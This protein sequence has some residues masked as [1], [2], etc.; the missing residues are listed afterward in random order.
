MTTERDTS[1]L[2]DESYYL[3]RE[4]AEL[5]FQRRVLAE[6]TDD[7]NPVLERVKFLAILTQNLDEFFM[8]RIGGLKQQIEAGIDDPTVDGMTPTEQWRAAI[9]TAD[10]LFEAQAACWQRVRDGVL[11]DAGIDVV[12]Y[13]D[14]APSE[15]ERLDDYFESDVLPTLTP[16][17]FDPAHPFPHISNQSLSIAVLTRD[18]ADEAGETTFSRVKVP[19][20]RPRLVAVGD[21]TFVP[22]EEVI[23]HNLDALFPNV[24]VVDHSLF[25]VTRNA[26]VRRNESVAEDLVNRIEAVLKERRFAT[27]VRLEVES[28]T[29]DA[30]V[31]LL[32]THLDLAAEEVFELDGLL[33]YRGL[34]RLTDLD[35]PALKLDAWTPRD[36]PRLPATSGPGVFETIREGDVLVH[37]PYHSFSRT[38]QTFFDAA[39][40]DPDVLAIKAAIYRTAR[41]SKI[42]ESLIE[43][44]RNGKQVAVMVELKARFDEE[45]NLRWVERLEEEGIHVAYGTLGHKAHTKTALVV[46]EE[47]EGVRLYSHVAT[48]NYHSETAEKY[49]DIGLLTANR[50]IGNDL[51]ALF[52]YFTGHSIPQ[53][54]RELL[55]APVGMRERFLDL[56][57]REAEHA[58]DGEDAR[59]V[60]K[61]NRLEHPTVVRAL[62]EAS[63]AGVDIDLVVRDICRLR[64]GLDGVSETVSVRSIVGRFLEH[65]RIF[66][67]E[68]TGD[69]D[70]FIGSADWMVRNLD[71]R[72]EAVTPVTDDGLRDYLDFALDTLLADNWNAW[73]MNPD[74]TYDAVT[75]GD[76]AVVNAHAVF[77]ERAAA[78][79]RVRDVPEVEDIEDTNYD[80]P[81]DV[82]GDASDPARP[83]STGRG[84]SDKVGESGRDGGNEES[85]DGGEGGASS[86]VEG[87]ESL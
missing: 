72:V 7:R 33:D 34:F 46:R 66:Y 32:A 39:A 50:G 28:G 65:S 43:A 75:P 54:S 57:E 51:V 45:N 2:D 62:Y 6:A 3:N 9:E 24:D 1:D 87:R 68:N 84:G 14:V 70:Y 79:A 53:N 4:L 26:E 13:E 25:R 36:H 60:A 40:R 64:P 37:H 80:E 42:I 67:F 38:V 12:G 22:L 31:D 71:N 74:G 20:N 86:A 44:A 61:M 81:V 48:G 47:S 56:I 16:L 8:K 55:V 23:R 49:E 29:P 10:E 19:G 30:V 27:V 73:E 18:D 11:A 63:R 17:T 76:D 58:R 21:E 82:G 41:D 78:E 77:M 85:G 59:I 35:R 69:P 15:R 52:N 5:A 83:R